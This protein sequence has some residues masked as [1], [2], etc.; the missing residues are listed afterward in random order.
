MDSSVFQSKQLEKEGNVDF[1][2]LFQNI[3]S[4][5]LLY[6]NKSSKRSPPCWKRKRFDMRKIAVVMVLVVSCAGI[7]FLFWS[8]ELKYVLPTPVPIN[9]RPKEVR[10][11]INLHARPEIPLNTS[12]Y[13]HFFNP[14]C[15]CSRFNLQHFNALVREFGNEVKVFAVIP[16]YGD[17]DRAVTM[18][19]NPNVTV[20]QDRDDFLASACGVYAT[21]QAVI[22]DSHQ[23]LFYRGNYNKSRYCTSKESNYAEIALRALVSGQEPPPSNSLAVR[24]YGCELPSAEKNNTTI[25][26][27]P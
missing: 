1:F 8:Q 14:D 15:P 10:Q 4:V 22:I 6:P 7:A 9:Y 23:K 11:V 19:D 27:I 25:S 20:L 18:I 5:S 12:L 13:F 24:S 3:N 17:F 16:V 26:I 2:S 21:P